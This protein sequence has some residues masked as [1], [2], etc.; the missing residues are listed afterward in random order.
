M[1]KEVIFLLTILF[2]LMAGCVNE[3]KKFEKTKIHK[4]CLFQ[5][6]HVCTT[7]PTCKKDS[8]NNSLDGIYAS[9]DG[10]V[11]EKTNNV[12]QHCCI[13]LA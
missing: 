10:W 9:D 6:N 5:P 3:D 13:R 1:K 7:D 12:E 8:L 11:C 2:L 4:T